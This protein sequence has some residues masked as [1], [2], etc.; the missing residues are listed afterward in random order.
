MSSKV[1]QILTAGLFIIA[2]CILFVVLFHSNTNTSEL[3]EEASLVLENYM[4][5]Y[6]KGTPYAVEYAHF[7]NEFIREAYIQSGDKMLDYNI[8]SIEKI[9]EYLYALTILIKTE[10]SILHQGDEYARAYNFMAL[11]D[12][13]WYFLNGVDNIPMNIQTNLDYSQ[14]EYYHEDIV[15]V[16]DVTGVVEF[17]LT[18]ET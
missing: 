18:S 4:E 10:Q 9:N 12:D 17:D 5:E 14:Y 13:R 6:K 3:P 16:E 15:P 1:K 7:E 2:V 11:I 8:E